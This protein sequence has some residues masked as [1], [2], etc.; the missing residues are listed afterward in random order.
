MISDLSKFGINIIYNSPYSPTF[1]AI[2]EFF[3]SLKKKIE[4]TYLKSS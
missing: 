4:N 2:E 3:G 1:S